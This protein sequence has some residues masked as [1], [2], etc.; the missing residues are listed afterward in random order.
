MNLA[1]LRHFIRSPYARRP[2]L[3]ALKLA[4]RLGISRPLRWETSPKPYREPE[5]L[6]PLLFAWLDRLHLTGRP[7]P[8]NRIWGSDWAEADLLRLCREGPAPGRGLAADARTLWEYGRAHHAAQTAA[9]A[10]RQ[11]SSDEEAMRLAGWIR[12]WEANN[13]FPD[14]AAWLC[15]MDVAIR[16]VN[17]MAADVLLGGRLRQA[18]GE[19]EWS[20]SLWNH[21]RCIWHRLE[22]RLILSNHYIANLLGLAWLGAAFCDTAPGARWLELARLEFPSAL[23]TQCRR[24]GGAIEASVPYHGLYAEL[25]LL[26]LPL[27]GN[28]ATRRS[29]PVLQAL[30]RVC[31]AMRRPVGDW[32][33]IGDDDSG[34][35]LRWD[36]LAQESRADQILALAETVMVNA[37]PRAEPAGSLFE[38]SGWW[39]SRHPGGFC[40]CLSFGGVG[41]HGWGGHAHNDRL[42]ICVDDDR[43][44]IFVD[45]GTFVYSADPAA[46]LRYRSVLAHNTLF[47][48]GHEHRKLSPPDSDHLFVL[49]GSDRAAH[50]VEHGPFRIAVEDDIPAEGERVR[51]HRAVWIHEESVEIRDRIFGTSPHLL[52]WRFHLDPA[53]SLEPTERG[54]ILASPSRRYRF[55]VAEPLELQVEIGRVSP[56]YGREEPASVLVAARRGSLP[57][58]ATWRLERIG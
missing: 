29:E 13:P 49:R 11:G 8:S 44:P 55:T 47:A 45:P 27:L 26:S 37:F 48:D 36:P 14:G 23:R 25:A 6:A 39:S 28:D 32:W 52:C 17:W 40:A 31:A 50:V 35:V 24:D 9:W 20:A 43:Q 7:M 53:I 56:E 57:A 12:Q 1:D 46:R 30:C 21:A 41:F 3:F 10:R 51:V 34:R 54:W 58:S 22:T 42:S 18:F 15:S 5:A 2:S 33:R 38:D 16:A 19:D 4:G